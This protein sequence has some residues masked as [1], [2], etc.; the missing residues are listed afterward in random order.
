MELWEGRG[1]RRLYGEWL[2]ALQ[3]VYYRTEKWHLQKV[4][5]RPSFVG[6]VIE[7]KAE[8]GKLQWRMRA[9][10]KDKRYVVG[11]WKSLRPGSISSGYMSMQLAPN[12]TFMCG[13]NY[14]DVAGNQDSN[15]GILLLGRTETDLR[16]A[17]QAASTG[18]R[19]IL[20]LTEAIDFFGGKNEPHALGHSGV[21]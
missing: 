18:T 6:I 4:I 21:Q 12:G 5:S 14:G 9:R 17:W 19:T 1:R 2:A 16:G 11:R 13:H 15:F 3:P 20:P 8:S 7:A 10:L